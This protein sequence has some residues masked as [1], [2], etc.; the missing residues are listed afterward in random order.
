[1]SSEGL[2]SSSGIGSQPRQEARRTSR[3][4]SAVHLVEVG[5]QG[6]VFQHTLALA[7]QLAAEGISTVIHTADD[8][9]LVLD[10]VDFCFC[11]SWQR[12]EVFRGPRIALRYLL[13]TLPHL[14][15]D[16]SGLVWV[17]GTFKSALT[18]IAIRILKAFNKRV[19]FSPHN[20]FS[21]RGSNLDF[22][23]IW[24]SISAADLVVV[25]NG[26]DARKVEEHRISCLQIP[27]EMYTPT[28][29]R[30][31]AE[32]W[33]SRLGEDRFVVA[34]IGQIRPDKNIGLLVESCAQA[35]ARLVVMGP[36]SGG[37]AE[38]QE[39]FPLAALDVLWL[40]GYH[41][42]EDLAAVTALSD[43]VALSYSLSS[44]SA[45][46]SLAHAYGTAVIAHGTGGLDE[47]ADAVVSTLEV[48]DWSSA[49]KAL[50]ET[51][52]RSKRS[53]LNGSITPTISRL[54]ASLRQTLE[55]VL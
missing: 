49:I 1:M 10:G 3:K 23:F 2:A 26:R 38:V 24:R 48:S 35:G 39:R 54:P 29:N 20:M 28:V 18:Y 8:C 43:C 32:K 22:G 27:L 14:I 6:G 7:Q 55:R 51:M 16:T 45:A 25:Y 31:T 30:E 46:A 33:A 19:F 21:R 41:D 5:G 37:A 44:Q 52:P 42:M 50:S 9:E 53:S 15:R 36:D 11:F 12:S 40:E 47:Q 17:Q 4:A 13:F 34:S